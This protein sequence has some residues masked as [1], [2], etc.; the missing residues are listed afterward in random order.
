ML[1]FA[2]GRYA[3]GAYQADVARAE[4]DASEARAAVALARSAALHHGHRE[5]L[6]AGAPMARIVI[7]RVGLDAIVLE[8]VDDDELN[9]GP[10]HLPGSAYPGEPGNAVISAHRDRHFNHLDALSVGDTVVTESGTHTTTWRIVAKR[11][12][13]KNDPALFRTSD[14]TLTLTTCWPIRYV[15]PAPERLILTAK[16]LHNRTGTAS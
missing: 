5:A 16:P 12:I 11:V 8:G 4:W 2:G 1:S 6:V 15:G 3:L 9:A 14:A 13:D 10:G 7:P